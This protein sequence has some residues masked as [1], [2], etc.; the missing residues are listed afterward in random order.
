MAVNQY[1]LTTKENKGPTRP[2]K[3]KRRKFNALGLTPRAEEHEDSDEDDA[4][5]E[6]KLSGTHGVQA[7]YGSQGV[8][9]TVANVL[10]L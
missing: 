3:K 5:E 9:P 10:V 2:K 8:L 4:D 6:T 1:I 7:Q